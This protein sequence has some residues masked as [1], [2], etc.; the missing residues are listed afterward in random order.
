MILLTF[1]IR[2]RLLGRAKTIYE[3]NIR[4][5][6]SS[7]SNQIMCHEEN[8]QNEFKNCYFN[9]MCHIH[10]MNMVK[11]RLKHIPAEKNRFEKERRSCVVG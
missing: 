8:G 7:S 2:V 10:H 4:E 1:L 11:P 3:R 6:N 5:E 9:H